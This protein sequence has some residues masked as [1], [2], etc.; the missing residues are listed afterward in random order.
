MIGGTGSMQRRANKGRQRFK[1]LE[2]MCIFFVLGMD[3]LVVVKS[4]GL[5]S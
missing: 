5:L 2:W 1:V 4:V 3:R